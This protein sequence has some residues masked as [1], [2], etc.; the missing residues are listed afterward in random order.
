[1]KGHNNSLERRPFGLGYPLWSFPPP[2]Y[3]YHKTVIFG[4]SM[5]LAGY[6]SPPEPKSR[7][8]GG[9]RLILNPNLYEVVLH[10]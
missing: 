3:F 10:N 5:E 1:M 7:L 4:Y 6:P 8:I 9:L 2:S